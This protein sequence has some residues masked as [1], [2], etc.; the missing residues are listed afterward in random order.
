MNQRSTSTPKTIQNTPKTPPDGGGGG[1]PVGN[2]FV[3]TKDEN[4]VAKLCVF[5][6]AWFSLVLFSIFENDYIFSQNMLNMQ[7]F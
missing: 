5:F 2:R 4:Y 3:H 7:R 6:R 1:S